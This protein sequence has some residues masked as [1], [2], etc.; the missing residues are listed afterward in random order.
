M[1]PAMAAKPEIAIVGPGRLGS[2]L[3]VELTKRG[4]RVREIV[5]SNR[6]ASV[7][8]ARQLAHKVHGQ[9][10]TPQ[11]ARLDAD[12]IWFCVPDRA[13]ARAADG[14]AAATAWKGRIALHS[15]GALTSDELA[16]LRQ[17]GAAV[18]SVHP[19]M[20]FVRGSSPSLR[21]VPLGVEGDENAVRA[22]ARIVRDLG[23]QTFLIRRQ[24]KAAYHAWGTFASP[25]LLAALVTA[26][27]LARL[28][29]V[30]A[31]TARRK[32]LPIVR[33]TIENYARLGPAA[34]FSGPI[35]RGDAAIV[36][37]HLRVLRATPEAREV[38]VA[39]ARAALRYLP[40]R[41]RKQIEKALNSR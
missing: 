10:S 7:R 39:L 24:D 8:R 15:S 14:L 12:L 25:L 2:I 18:A 19:L 4:Y 5:S 17:R 3:A 23:G 31:A 6:R 37:E 13:I 11:R 29:G 33:Q 22:A 36:R 28:A 16:A 34:A 32:M 20:T 40:A 35:V 30:P 38:Y 9:V 41:N 26:E 27:R 21:G 1:L